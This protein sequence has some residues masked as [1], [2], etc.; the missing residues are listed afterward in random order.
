VSIL[1]DVA[2]AAF[3]VSLATTAFELVWFE[4]DVAAAESRLHLG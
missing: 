1:A 4:A 3:S 2:A